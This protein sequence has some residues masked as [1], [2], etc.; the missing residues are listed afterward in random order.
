MA[1]RTEEA[2]WRPLVGAVCLMVA[3]AFMVVC[4]LLT[5]VGLGVPVLEV[6]DMVSDA[7]SARVSKLAASGVG[8]M[9]FGVLPL[10]CLGHY[11]AGGGGVQAQSAPASAQ[12]PRRNPRAN[13]YLPVP[14]QDDQAAVARRLPP[15]TLLH[16]PVL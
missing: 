13:T 4:V 9:A 11:L 6:L 15:A 1:Q 10:A 16:L 3:A 12:A 14:T 5:V 2:S 7:T 8:M